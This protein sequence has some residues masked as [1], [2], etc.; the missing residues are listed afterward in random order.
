MPNR[1]TILNGLKTC[2]ENITVAKGFHKSVNKVV[3]EFLYYDA[4][5]TFPALMI[6]GGEEVFEDEFGSCTLSRLQVRIIGYSK[7]SSNP[8]QEQCELL[9]DVLIC[10]N[11]DSY[12]PYKSKFRPIRVDTDEG[13]IHAAGEGVSM[14]ILTVEMI[15]KFE[16]SAP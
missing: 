12:N 13:L 7:N 9:E 2:L 3:R 4:V 6:L 1:D 16:R 15:Y 10:L 8:E 11:N 14:F 5:I